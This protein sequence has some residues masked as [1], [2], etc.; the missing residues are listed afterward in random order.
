MGVKNATVLHLL[1][2]LK[3]HVYIDHWP[4]DLEL[5]EHSRED[6]QLFAHEYK[7]SELAQIIFQDEFIVN[8]FDVSMITWYW[9][10]TYANF[11][12]QTTT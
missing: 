10:I 11:L 8:V 1:W 2:L 5:S 6:F 4:T 3:C 7:S 9:N 12:I